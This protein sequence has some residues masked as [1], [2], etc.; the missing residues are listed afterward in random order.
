MEFMKNIWESA[1]SDRKKIV[2][3]EGDEDRTLIA[4]EKINKE[5][6]ADIILVGS[7]II[8]KAKA[9]VLG[10]DIE[11]IQ[12]EDPETS[13]NT[14]KYAEEFYEL[15]KKKGMTKEKALK[16]VKDPLYYGTMMVKMNDANGM[17][18]GAIHTTGDLLRPGLQIIKTAPGVSV[19]SSFFIMMVPDHN[20]GDDGMLIFSDCAVNPNPTA[21]ELAT[22]AIATAETAKKL[23]KIEPKV[24][25][26]SFST[27]G[28][29]EHE[30][31]E[32]V[33]NATQIAKDRRPD[34]DIDGEMQLDA[35]IVPKVAN[36]KA[37]NSKVAGNANV[38]IFPDLQSGN[39]GYKLVQRFGRAEAIGPIS[40]G[41]AK[42]INDLS[43]G[44]S[45]E[46]IVNVVALTAV[47]AQ[48]SK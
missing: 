20:Y 27:M 43:R 19:V 36:Q 21:D 29:A 30:L 14:E 26:L 31:V 4:S 25:M 12:I 22:I 48:T 45:S 1:K 42:P 37:P 23:C 16:I 3:P 44:C 7:S 34:L 6:L 47:Q 8:I 15:R 39:I 24:A 28:S 41:F 32:K 33:R 9:K 11:G 35:A 17:V 10:L 40:Q 18:S 46:D 2:L 5:G 38:L 13:S